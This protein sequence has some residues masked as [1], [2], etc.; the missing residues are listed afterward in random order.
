MRDHTV[1]P[2][3]FG[4]DL[5]D[6]RRHPRLLRS[7]HDAFVD[8]LEDAEQARVRLEGIVDRDAIIR[9]LGSRTDIRRLKNEIAS[10]KGSTY[11]AHAV[12]P[13]IESASSAGPSTCPASSRAAGRRG[14][15]AGP[16]TVGD[17]I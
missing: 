11:C 5:Q 12:W 16:Q 13:L 14:G 9:E 10:Q 17:K 6:A 1:I 8:V 2:M 7:A 4:A 15:G 3:S